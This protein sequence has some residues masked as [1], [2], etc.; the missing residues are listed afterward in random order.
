MVIVTKA[1]HVEISC[2]CCRVGIQRM[3]GWLC[4]WLRKMKSHENGSLG[5]FGVRADDL[6]TNRIGMDQTVRRRL[7]KATRS[8]E[9]AERQ[10]RRR[11]AVSSRAY[12]ICPQCS[13]VG[14][15]KLVNQYTCNGCG[16]K[17]DAGEFP[18]CQENLHL[19]RKAVTDA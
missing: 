13:F 17:P 15:F 7:R 11:Y 16:T 19:T 8:D 5:W 10:Q 12:Q 4:G 3:S 14:D 9:Y 6:G 2:E 1:K 18:A